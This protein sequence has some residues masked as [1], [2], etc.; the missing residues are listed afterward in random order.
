MTL[1]EYLTTDHQKVR[2]VVEGFSLKDVLGRAQNLEA[3]YWNAMKDL[4]G[5][6]R[7]TAPKTVPDGRLNRQTKTSGPFGRPDE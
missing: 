1:H 6:S 5:E 4:L 7:M 2:E 3:E